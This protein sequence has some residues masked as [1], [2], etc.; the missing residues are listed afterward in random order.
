MSRGKYLSL[1][2]ARK[3]DYLWQWGNHQNYALCMIQKGLW[4][5]IARH[6]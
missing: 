2:E 4:E 6:S 5:S 1:E 3:K